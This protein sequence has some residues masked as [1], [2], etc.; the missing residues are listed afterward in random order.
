[1]ITF[2]KRMSFRKVV[3]RSYTPLNPNSIKHLKSI[4][5]LF[6]LATKIQVKLQIKA[7]HI[8]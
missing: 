4:H 7:R 1:M 8:N 3:G 6:D 5:T 2:F